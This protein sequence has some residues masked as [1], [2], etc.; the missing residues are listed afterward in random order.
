MTDST[1]R[2]AATVIVLREKQNELEVLLLQRSKHSAFAPEFWVFPGGK[3]DDADSACGDT[4][5]YQA[6]LVAAQRECEEEAGL[7]L[8]ASGYDYYSQWIT[9]AT[10][11][12][13]FSTRFFL[14][15]CSC[16]TTVNIDGHEIT[17][18]QWA[19]PTAILALHR[20]RQLRLLP[21]TF[22]SLLELSQHSNLESAKQFTQNRTPPVYRP[23]L[24]K[25]Q[26]GHC[27]LYQED[28]GY[29]D[30][31]FL[32][33]GK[34]HRLVMAPGQWQYQKSDSIA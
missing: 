29:Q 18:Y 24:I 28:S 4:F 6:S 26:Q 1:L 5:S 3:V 31:V 33:E 12:V 9:P 34:R 16:T 7:T 2:P 21:P 13:R 14:T 17:D 19:K 15:H 27:S 8:N 10:Y 11:G 30:G 25:H 22:V 20:Q 32:N 23:K